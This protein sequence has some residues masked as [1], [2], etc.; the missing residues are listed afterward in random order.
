MSLFQSIF[1]TG[2]SVNPLPGLCDLLIDRFQFSRKRSSLNIVD[3][4]STAVSLSVNGTTASFESGERTGSDIVEWTLDIEDDWLNDLLSEIEADDVFYDVGANLG[5][6]SCFVLNE[7]S[8][9]QVVAFEP[10]PPNIQQLKRNLSRNG[11]RYRVIEKALADDQ[12]SQ[13][14]TESGG[15]VGHPTGTISP[16]GDEPGPDIETIRGDELVR[17]EPLPE[18]DIVKI[19]VEGSEPLVLE[20]LES[21][22]SRTDC[23][24]VYCEIHLPKDC[25]PSVWDY[26]ES[27]DDVKDRLVECGYELE[28]VERRNQELHV[29]A[30][31]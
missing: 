27:P 7:L 10:Y 11:D 24:V 19:D 12:A 9:G 29:K 23:R 14:F 5:V 8:E 16:D 3:N 22:L 25:R 30:V 13:S 15:E 20:G 2:Q 4:E 6:Y 1:D 17:T 21:T 18:P 26:G 28:N 31:R